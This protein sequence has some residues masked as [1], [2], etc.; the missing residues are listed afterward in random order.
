MNVSEWQ[1]LMAPL[2]H[3][4]LYTFT[5]EEELW[6]VVG[7]ATDVEIA[8]L[9]THTYFGHL[10]EKYHVPFNIVMKCMKSFKIYIS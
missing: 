7:W 8:Q 3:S 5:K 2:T 9:H 10:A 1:N 6:A 4:C